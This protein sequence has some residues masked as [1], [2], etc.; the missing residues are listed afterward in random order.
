MKIKK[1]VVI[2][3]TPLWMSWSCSFF[4]CLFLVPNSISKDVTKIHVWLLCFA[5]SIYRLLVFYYK[6]VHVS[7]C[8]FIE[9]FPRAYQGYC[10]SSAFEKV[11]FGLWCCCPLSAGNGVY[12]LCATWLFL[13]LILNNSLSVEEEKKIF[14]LFPLN[15]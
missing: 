10:H 13:P 7:M 5:E 3:W 9:N 8:T 11:I 2:K 14:P 1:N 6:F 4:V 12:H 15:F